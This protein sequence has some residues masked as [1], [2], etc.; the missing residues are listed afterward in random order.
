LA[1]LLPDG[2]R[3]SVR[4]VVG[5]G[6]KGKIERVDKKK[7]KIKVDSPPAASKAKEEKPK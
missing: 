6:K 5:S 3:L 2:R 1:C 7:T 4:V